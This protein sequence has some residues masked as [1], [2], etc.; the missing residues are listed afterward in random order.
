MAVPFVSM[1]LLV[2]DTPETV[3]ATAAL[4]IANLISQ[5]DGEFSIG[6]AGG[7][8]PEATY[9]ALVELDVAWDSVKTWLSDERWVPHDHQ[10]SNGRMATEALIHKINGSLLRPRWGDLLEPRDSAADYES[11]LR[12]IHRDRHPDLVL[13]GMGDDGHT[14]SLFPHTAALDE[15][16]RWFVANDVP[17]LREERLTATFPLLWQTANIIVLV[18]G[19][20]KAKALKESFAG[21]TPAGRLGEGEAEV[22]W[23]VDEAA[24]S[25]LS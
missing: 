6:L 11:S 20:K 21:T 9:R 24:A 4:R 15:R 7:S 17:Q 16:E 13:L 5:A 12:S 18:V 14:A 23:F 8:T 10:R 25:L 3:A 19:S 22:E 2:H 1:E